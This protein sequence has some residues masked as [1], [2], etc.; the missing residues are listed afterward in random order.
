M[1][2]FQ[3]DYKI[4]YLGCIRGFKKK[5]FH[6]FPIFVG[7]QKMFLKIKKKF[8]DFKDMF[9]KILMLEICS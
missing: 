1:F 8:P 9:I 2:N 7:F 3:S 6:I 5:Y 4:F